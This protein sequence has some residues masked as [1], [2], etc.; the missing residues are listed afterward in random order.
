MDERKKQLDKFLEME[1][2]YGEESISDI[3]ETIKRQLESG[4]S[5]LNK[6]QLEKTLERLIICQTLQEDAKTMVTSEKKPELKRND[7]ID[8]AHEVTSMDLPDDWDNAFLYDERVD[9]IH[10]ESIADGL[11]MSLST[12]GRVDIEYISAI[13]GE[14]Y[15]AVIKGLRG[16]IYQ[17][18]LKWD[19]RF[20]KGWE[21][22]EEY[23]SGNLMTKL[24]IAEDANED[25]DGYFADN[26]TAIKR[27]LPPRVATSDIYITLG[28]P[29]VP[30]DII[31]DF[32]KHLFGRPVGYYS[33][34]EL[35][36]RHDEITGSWEIPS[37]SRY[38]YDP[39]T[40]QTYG[41]RE[42]NALFI[43][44]KTLNMKT[45]AVYDTVIDY[46]TGK[47][48]RKLNK[49][50][51]L[52][53]QEKQRILI[54]EFKK[55]VWQSRERKERL[56][57]IYEMQF[58]CVRKRNFD[59]SFLTF[60][61]MKEEK[62]LYDYQKNAVARILFS[63]N[64]LLAHDVGAGKTFIMVAA[65]MELLRLKLSKKNLYVVPNNLVGQWKDIFLSLYP[66][67]N[68]FCVEP[69]I[70]TPKKRQGTLRKIRDESYDGIIM[71]YSCFEAITLSN[72]SY[73]EDLERKRQAIISMAEDSRKATKYLKNKKKAIDK[74]ITELILAARKVS[75]AEIPFDELGITRLFIDEAHNYKN[76]PIDTKTTHVLGI[77]TAG[78]KKCEDVLNKVRIV[79]KCN[80][81]G[82]V[83][84]ATGTPITNS[85]TDAY[86]VQQYL[87]PGQLS[88][89]DLQS[90]DSWIGM[91]AEK[92]TEFEIDVDTS[93]YRLATRFCRFHNLPELTTLLAAV[94]DFHSV[95]DSA[96]LP[97]SF[98]YK[99]GIIPRTRE[100]TAY[101]EE[102]SARADKVRSWKVDR[103]TDN[104]LKITTDGRKAA[105][106]LRL[107]VPSAPFTYSS[108]VATCAS[109][110]M[111]IYKT[112][113]LQRSTQL[114]FC[115]SST[116]KESFNVYDEMKRLLVWDGVEEEEIAY[117]HDATTEKKRTELFEKMSNGDVRILIGSTFKLGLGVNVQKKLI[118][119]HH[120][121][122]PW[123]PA[124]MTQR[125]GRIL[126]Q[127]NEN[128]SVA[129]FRYITEG[130]FDAYSW[131]LLETKQRFITELLSGQL[132][133]RFGSDIENT[134][135]DYAEVKA[136]AIGNPLI[137]KR[138]ETANELNRLVTLRRKYVESKADMEVEL[139]ELPNRIAE[140]KEK[141]AR[142]EKDIAHYDESWIDY[143]LMRREIREKLI[144][145][146]KDNVLQKCARE[147]MVYQGFSIVLPAN[148]IAERPYVYLVHE[149][150][151]F[152]E[153]GETGLGNLARIDNFFR[154]F[155][156]YLATLNDNLR[157]LESRKESIES[158]LS[159]E[160][161][162]TD[163][164]E[165]YKKKLKKIDKELGVI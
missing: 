142:C 162:L 74:Q 67:A 64:T 92:S 131:Q 26:V 114:I 35:L 65:G 40:T 7:D 161:D 158:E 60:P 157:K 12:L 147:L 55:W 52:L 62:K 115:D 46:N 79:Q 121:D 144:E 9:G 136:L 139:L 110:V 29:W 103:K 61:G 109:N 87:Q 138:V 122:V 44:E 48:K 56:E 105:L 153:L 81:G 156:E 119:I 25:Y 116:P 39:A 148:M 22:A 159:K 106:D 68:L 36:V 11:T 34:S 118:A 146:L 54:E 21:T 78:S 94:A 100:L 150:K 84:F 16:A 107:V 82:G 164:I 63:Q 132:T 3:I 77:N 102:I 83:I 23:L 71:A 125:E 160:T 137:K 98:G 89:L 129:I 20:Y 97:E 1:E 128:K 91:F 80:E 47:E 111:Y 33:P 5:P 113:K 96:V 152:V 140:Q 17:N 58:T 108:K 31:D 15:K 75:N 59:G 45:V 6:D 86:V 38:G 155:S 145:G 117:I 53:A 165:K 133:T 124:D 134:V 50:D 73:R 14:T 43:L 154:N 149:G 41:L 120:L 4:N 163:E 42:M 2:D 88:L 143:G 13:T 51:T 28:S 101:L 24:Q 141:I 130:S 123:R 151:Y 99:D 126:R 69:K 8:H 49:D 127:G 10:V 19:E 76:V 30:S 104:M 72:K 93:G 27:I 32:I 18:P 66:Q 37:K 90:F 57:H 95:D 85:I 135:L 70:F 112:T